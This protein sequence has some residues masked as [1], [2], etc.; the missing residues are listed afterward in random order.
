MPHCKV[1]TIAIVLYSNDH[2]LKNLDASLAAFNNPGTDFYRVARG[3]FWNIGVCF[4]FN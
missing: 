4:C 3:D 2:T 1:G